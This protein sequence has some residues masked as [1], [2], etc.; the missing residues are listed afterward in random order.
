MVNPAY[1]SKDFQ[2]CFL[3]KN[4]VNIFLKKKD[5]TATSKVFRGQGANPC[6]PWKISD[7]CPRMTLNNIGHFDYF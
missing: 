2:H 7:P 6:D 3:F 5:L 1:F 4:N